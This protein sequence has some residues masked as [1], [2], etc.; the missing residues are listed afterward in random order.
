MKII[1]YLLFLEFKQEYN[2]FKYILIILM[3]ALHDKS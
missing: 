2:A 1:I 3:D